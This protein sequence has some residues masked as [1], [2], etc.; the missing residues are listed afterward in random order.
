VLVARC[1]SQN[2]D[3][4]ERLKADLKTALA[5]SGVELPD[6]STAHH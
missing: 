4:L 5:A 3:G 1:E 6:E 2:E